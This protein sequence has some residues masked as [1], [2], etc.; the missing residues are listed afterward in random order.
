MTI[1]DK[2]DEFPID[3]DW[4]ALLSGTVKSKFNISSSG[5]YKRYTENNWIGKWAKIGIK[6]IDNPAVR[7]LLCETCF[8]KITDEKFCYCIQGE[9]IE[10][11][12]KFD[13][14]GFQC[15]ND[16]CWGSYEQ[17]FQIK[18]KW[19]IQREFS[20]YE[21]MFT[22]KKIM[23]DGKNE[24]CL[25]RTF[26]KMRDVTSKGNI[27]EGLGI[28]NTK[29]SGTPC[30]GFPKLIDK[31]EETSY[32]MHVTCHQSPQNNENIYPQTMVL[33]HF[34]KDPT[35]KD[36]PKNYK[37]LSDKHHP[38]ALTV[39]EM[40]PG[41]AGCKMLQF[42]YLQNVEFKKYDKDNWLELQGL[43]REE[44]HTRLKWEG[45]M[46]EWKNYIDERGAFIEFQQNG[47]AGPIIS[48]WGRVNDKNE[49]FG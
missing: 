15:T 16:A 31:E 26:M 44:R 2:T 49:W 9:P 12:V 35:C 41:A 8:L 10:R 36:I 28:V 5:P 18:R 32:F 14:S 29:S 1:D 20:G 42:K 25:D 34:Q 43:P 22:N 38:V 27:Y 37:E 21:Y 45:W 48:Y 24:E 11:T 19:R 46:T 40:Y 39:I 3:K 30:F 33:E 23:I 13:W 7:K 17:Y 4:E 6:A 47:W